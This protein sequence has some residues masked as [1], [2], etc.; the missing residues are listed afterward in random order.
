MTRT[1]YVAAC[2]ALVERSGA[3]MVAT[4]TFA[5]RMAAR[6][7]A[8]ASVKALG[9]ALRTL[10]ADDRPACGEHFAIVRE[11]VT[12]QYHVMVPESFPPT[13]RR[14]WDAWERTQRTA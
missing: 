9:S 5:D 3:A 14:Q 4:D 12:D 10:P 7:D 1:E 8:L 6:R 2:W 13:E 11:I